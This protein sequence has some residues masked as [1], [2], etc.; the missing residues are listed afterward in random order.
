MYKLH[1]QKILKILITIV[2][3]NSYSVNAINAAILFNI[4]PHLFY[5]HRRHL[6]IVTRYLIFDSVKQKLDYHNYYYN[7]LWNWHQVAQ[8]VIKNDNQ[9]K[10][11]LIGYKT[12]FLDIWK[13][14]VIYLMCSITI[15]YIP[16]AF[17]NRN[18]LILT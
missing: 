14:T 13:C 7:V 6:Y 5:P 12:Y 10:L 9:I 11:W 17:V 18:T 3:L 1:H 15:Q 16:S 2:Y 4:S 8:K